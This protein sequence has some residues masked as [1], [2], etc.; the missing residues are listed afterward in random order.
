VYDSTAF[1]SKKTTIG[2]SAHLVSPDTLVTECNNLNI[3]DILSML[4][5]RNNLINDGDHYNLLHF[6]KDNICYTLAT[7]FDEMVQAFYD[8]KKK[9]VEVAH[10][11]LV[12]LQN[13]IID[14]GVQAAKKWEHYAQYWCISIFQ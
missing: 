3:D 2:P 8:N 5:A 7:A 6:D 1:G 4:S 14:I 12:A 9:I 10:G 11:A 13:I